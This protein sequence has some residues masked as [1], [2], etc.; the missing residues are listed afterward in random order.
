MEKEIADNDFWN[1]DDTDSVILEVKDLKSIV[2]P[3][4]KLNKRV[5]DNVELLNQIDDEDR[6][7]I[8]IVSLDYEKD[9]SNY[10]KLELETFLSG[11]Y[12]G[13]NCIL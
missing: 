5:N 3:I 4:C 6:E 12:D 13:N 8:N 9:I 7:F 2:E 10:E 1:R 11:K